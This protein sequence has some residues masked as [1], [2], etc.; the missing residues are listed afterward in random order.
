MSW[1]EVFTGLGYATG[2][3]VLMWAARRKKLA[4]EGMAWVGL[5]GFIGGLFGAKLTELVFIGWPITVSFASVFDPR[6]GGRALLGG[7]LFG[8]LAVV[9]AK[10]QLGIRRSTGDLFGLALPAGEAVGR[11]G[12]FLNGCCYGTECSGPVAVYQHGALRHPSQLYSALTA[13]MIFFVLI[14]LDRSGRLSKEGDLFRVYLIC[15]GGT[16]FGLE[17]VRQNGSFWFG[18]TPMQWFCLELLVFGCASLLWRWRRV[19]AQA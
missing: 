5:W 11:I 10:R 18:L 2:L 7:V 13:G 9:F 16:R 8:W 12:C 6:S 4:T 1:G 19:E 15:F 14:W 3:T 17:F